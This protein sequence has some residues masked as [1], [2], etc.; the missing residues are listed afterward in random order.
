MT[1]KVQTRCPESHGTPEGRPVRR[2]GSWGSWCYFHS[3]YTAMSRGLRV[4]STPGPPAH[5]LRWGY[6]SVHLRRREV[7]CLV[8]SWE[9]QFRSSGWPDSRAQAQHHGLRGPGWL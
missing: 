1:P 9:T 5:P 4:H 3:G 8:H 2:A 7:S 6:C